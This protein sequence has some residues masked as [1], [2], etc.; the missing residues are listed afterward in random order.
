MTVVAEEAPSTPVE[1]RE[2]K[3]RLAARAFAARVGLEERVEILAEVSTRW[4]DPADRYRREGLRSL[5]EEGGYSPETA[6]A[7]L[8]ATLRPWTERAW[9][10]LARSELGPVVRSGSNGG[11]L[12]GRS[13][14]RVAP[15]PIPLV[16]GS[17]LPAPNLLPLFFALLSGGAPIAKAGRRLPSFPAVALASVA[18]VDR[19][20]AGC[21]CTVRWDRAR[22]DLTGALL[23]GAS[24]VSVTGGDEAVAAI[25]SRID[26]AT[27][28]LAHPHKMSFA[29]VGASAVASAEATIASAERLA[30]DVAL[31]DQ[32]GCLSPVGVLVEASGP[33]LRRF[34]RIL[35]E[36]LEDRARA[37]P[38]STPS[39]GEAVAIRSF[40]DRFVLAEA[41]RNGWRVLADPGLAWV[42]GVLRRGEALPP[43]ALFRCVWVAPVRDPREADRLL[44]PWRGIT[45]AIGFKGSGAARASARALARSL[46]ASRFCA[47]GRMQSPPL[48]WRRDGIRPVRGFLP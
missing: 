48:S 29:Y 28:L 42:V 25:R 13:G 37:W 9:R 16:L 2:L 27:R 1:L 10:E 8:D 14:T 15:Q 26:P 44:R 5:V 11:R 33:D 22:M 6:A 46:G 32:H 23:E 40:H 35:A 20:L 34:A 12:N 45:A 39:P 24:V 18:A 30:R 43:P 38:R 47:L 3:R 31:H 36:A 4:S 41:R 21:G 7:G 17:A 19:G